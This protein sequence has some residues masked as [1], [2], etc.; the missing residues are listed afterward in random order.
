MY[1]YLFAKFEVD[2]NDNEEIRR[3]FQK[4]LQHPE[5]DSICYNFS[6]MVDGLLFVKVISELSR[7]F[8]L[9]G[10]Q[11]RG[12]TKPK[13]RST[14]VPVSVNTELSATCR[15]Q[16]DFNSTHVS[17][18]GASLQLQGN[19][20]HQ[21]IRCIIILRGKLGMAYGSH[22]RA[23]LWSPSTTFQKAAVT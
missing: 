12:A 20:V 3:G 14:L 5:H 16:R 7:A 13:E 23:C 6:M 9:I 21:F 17:A 10:V 2:T 22:T 8:V 19:L 11:R 4:S 1:F 15:Q 18:S